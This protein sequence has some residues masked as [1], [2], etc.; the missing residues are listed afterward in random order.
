MLMEG[1]GWGMAL[2][3]IGNKKR[4]SLNCETTRRRRRSF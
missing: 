3:R 1:K 2:A 4:I